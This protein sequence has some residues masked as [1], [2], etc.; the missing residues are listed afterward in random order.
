[1]KKFSLK[2]NRPLDI[3]I[4]IAI[5]LVVGFLLFMSFF[6]IYLPRSTNHG[7][8]ITVPSLEGMHIDD[9]DDFLL[10]RKLRWEVNDSVFSDDVPPLT[11]LRQYPKPGS[12]VKENRKIFIS[13]NRVNP[14]TVP[15][16][17]LEE[18]SLVNA[19]TFLKSNE[20]K[21][22]K[23]TY[24]PNPFSNLVLE[25]YHEGKQLSEGDRVP[26]GSVIDLVVGDG[27]GK[28]FFEAPSLVGM[29]YYEA[30]ILIRGS[31]LQLGEIILEQDTTNR[32]IYVVR[33]RPASGMNIRLDD[34][35]DLWLST[36]N[37]LEGVLDEE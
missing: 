16:H 33:Q 32:K 1:M 7:E 24:K 26:K 13:V 8:T 29:E 12:K 2:P 6:Y 28:S 9:L 25:I 5:V 35:V 20:L 30:K 11:I 36:E 23:L 10:K 18:R 37:P 17:D 15:I 31:D 22:G 27:F 34:P 4:H 21:R 3:I 19:E 14:P